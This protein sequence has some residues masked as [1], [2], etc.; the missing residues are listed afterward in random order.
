MTEYSALK[1]VRKWQKNV[2]YSSAFF[3]GVRGGFFLALF[4]NT[5]R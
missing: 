4:Y 1:A 5:L 2:C 3:S